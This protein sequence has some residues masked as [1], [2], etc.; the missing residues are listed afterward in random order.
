M[1]R[2]RPTTFAALA[3]AALAIAG[4]ATGPSQEVAVLAPAPTQALP[5]AFPARDIVGRY[6]L[7]AYHKSEDAERTELA[8]QSQCKQ[9]YLIGAGPSGGVVMHLADQATPEELRLKGGPGGKTY[10]GPDAEAGGVQD[11]EVVSF[12]G[13]VL[14]LR[15]MDPEVQS[16]YGTMVYVRCGAEGAKRPPP[17][18]RS[19]T[20]P[21]SAA[22]PAAPW[23]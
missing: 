6:G 7:A 22:A 11:R 17:Q 21:K 3:L 4:C 20:R 13:R 23:Q 19:A 1:R 10:I 14:V 15:W 16:R 2:S 12:N 18:R 5:P 9:P 8:A